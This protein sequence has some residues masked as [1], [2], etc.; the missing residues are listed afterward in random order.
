MGSGIRFVYLI[1]SLVSFPEIVCWNS[2]I[3]AS[4]SFVSVGARRIKGRSDWFEEYPIAPHHAPQI[5]TPNA[6]GLL[7]QHPVF[8]QTVNQPFNQA[9][10]GESSK[11]QVC[12]L[13][14]FIWLIY[15]FL[16]RETN[17]KLGL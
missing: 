6:A 14:A 3:A 10:L 5:N 12:Q 2:F 17:V 9:T 11:Q 16:R 4:I 13:D 15:L 1:S 8:R 7:P